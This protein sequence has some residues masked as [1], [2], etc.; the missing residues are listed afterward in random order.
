MQKTRVRSL[1]PEDSLKKE[2]ATH[3][4]ILAWE[5]PWTEEPR[6]LQSYS[7]RGSKRATKQQPS[8]VLPEDNEAGA[9]HQK[10]TNHV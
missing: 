1:G 9:E 6:G 10:L 2:I 7:P 3:F 4:N 5:I 8:E